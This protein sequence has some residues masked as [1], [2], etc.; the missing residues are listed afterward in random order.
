MEEMC[1]QAIEYMPE[2]N[3]VLVPKCAY[4]GGKCTEFK[5]CGLN[6]KYIDNVNDK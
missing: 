1:R 3:G 4:R 5:C 2:L 6:K